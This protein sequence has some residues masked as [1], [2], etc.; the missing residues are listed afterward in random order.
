MD[1][2]SACYSLVE[3]E[4]LM[5]MKWEHKGYYDLDKRNLQAVTE[6][7]LHIAS[8]SALLIAQIF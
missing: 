3:T 5:G 8:S 2:N 6:R 7:P 4:S 1:K